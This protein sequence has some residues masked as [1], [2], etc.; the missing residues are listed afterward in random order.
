MCA[1]TPL[2]LAQYK[3]VFT[4]IG[5]QP[6]RVTPMKLQVKKV[7]EVIPVFCKPTRLTNEQTDRHIYGIFFR[8][9]NQQRA[10]HQKRDPDRG[11]LRQQD[12][13]HAD[14]P[15]RIQHAFYRPWRSI[16]APYTIKFYDL[17]KSADLN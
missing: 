12:M 16:H 5:K 11:E 7:N 10:H 2:K 8:P 13:L 3:E 15:H 6:I 14:T 17:Y 1:D 9:E 4:D